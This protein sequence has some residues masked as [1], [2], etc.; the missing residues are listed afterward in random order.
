MGCGSPEVFLVK[1]LHIL[2]GVRLQLL[3]GREST[4]KRMIRKQNLQE[5]LSGERTWFCLFNGQ[6]PAQIGFQARDFRCGERR[7][8]EHIGKKSDELRSEFRKHNTAD[9]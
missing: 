3:F 7:M 5:T 6:L 9:G 4:A 2:H 1:R 8:L